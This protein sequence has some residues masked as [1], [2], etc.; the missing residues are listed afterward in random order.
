[1]SRVHFLGKIPYDQFLA[2]M[3]VTKVHAYLTYPFVLSWSMLEAM[4]A[5]AV[6]VASATPPVQEVIRDGVNGRLVN[7]F[8]VDAWTATLIE[9]LSA[10]LDACGF[11]AQARRSI[12]E[13]YDLRT[14]CLPAQ[15]GFVEG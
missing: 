10:P 2:L 5:G 7:F 3:Q 4:S 11:G 15:I 12:I 6:V 8:D 14:I 1:M 13:A 9:A